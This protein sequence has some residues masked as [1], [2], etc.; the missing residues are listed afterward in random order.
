M[1][2][3]LLNIGHETIHEAHPALEIISHRG[4]DGF[5]VENFDVDGL[6]IAI[7]HRR[8]SIIDLSES[9]RQ[10]MSTASGNIWIIFNGEIYN[11]KELRKE[12]EPDG[13]QFKSSSD[14]EVILASYEKW[15]AKCLD[16]LNGMFAFCIYDKK[17]S[18]IFMAR[19]RFGIKPLYY[20]NTRHGFRAASEIKQFLSAPRFTP[21]INKTK[22]YHFLNS[23]D[24]NFDNESLWRNILEIEPGHCAEIDLKSWRPGDNIKI[25]KWYEPPFFDDKLNI[26][27]D[28]AVSEFNRLLQDSVRLR[29]RSDVPVGFLLSGGLDSSTLVGLAHLVP[30]ER[31]EKLKTYS[32]CYENSK[33]DERKFIDEMINFAKAEY[34]LH[35]PKPQDVVDNIANVIWHNDIPVLHGSPTVHWL[36]YQR[37]KQENDSRKVII[38]GQGG[39]EI[40]CGYGDFHWAALNEQ[41]HNSPIKFLKQ[42]FSF[43]KQHH[44]PLKIIARKLFRMN[45]PSAVKY[46]PNPLL[47]AVELVGSSIPEIAIRREEG[48]V[49]S[50]HRNRFRILRYILHNV[51]RNSMAHSREARTPFLDY[52]L[53][54]FCLK[55]PSELKISDGYS[56]KI[57]RKAAEKVIPAKIAKRTDKQ[58]Y[59]SPVA[60]WAKSGLRDFFRKNLAKFADLPFV[61][62]KLAQGQ[63]EKYLAGKANF[64]PVIWRIITTGIWIEK[65]GFR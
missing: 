24:F 18:T 54:E 12:L 53:V 2:G 48:D 5:G 8:L 3:I 1:C 20:L 59:S 28:D 60:Q 51:D 46:P 25:T 16:K 62:G 41:L 7:G 39:D 32:S 22:L 43:Q 55:L 49:R 33:I 63:F 44:E 65:F 50:L 56:K 64:D 37:I 9:G 17:N 11:Y 47:K 58:G 10:P 19:D 45:F 23:G 34:C 13:F 14:T 4:P 6:K 38:E 15:G 26:S 27:F 21:E 40:A 52:R 36:L 57:L 30:E 35:F 31:N 61:N 29:L 42:F